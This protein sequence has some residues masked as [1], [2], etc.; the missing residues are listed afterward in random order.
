M[1]T[2]QNTELTGKPDSDF[3]AKIETE[4]DKTCNY[5]FISSTYYSCITLALNEICNIQF[6]T[7]LFG[8]NVESCT[9][10]ISSSNNRLEFSIQLENCNKLSVF[11]NEKSLVKD[12]LELIEKICDKLFINQNQRSIRLQFEFLSFTNENA[13]NRIK[14]LHK[15]L[16]IN[17]LATHYN[18]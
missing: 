3:W 4:I 9:F 7:A 6:L 10:R 16:N 1:Q 5:F 15:Y 12:T 11:G 17:N 8:V 18:I 14:L 2:F 13:L